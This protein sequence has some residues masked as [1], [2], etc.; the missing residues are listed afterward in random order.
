MPRGHPKRARLPV[1]ARFL[2][3]NAVTVL[4]LL[5]HPALR[6]GSINAAMANA[7][8][9]LSGVTV[10]DLYADYPRFDIDVAREQ[11]RLLEHD[12]VVIQ[13]PIFWYAT[14]ALLKQWL[15]VVLEYGFAYG[16]GASGLRGK[17][18]ALAVTAGGRPR[19]YSPDGANAYR[20]EDFLLPLK[21]TAALCGMIALPPFMLQEATHIESESAQAHIQAYPALLKALRDETLD[22]RKLGTMDSIGHHNLLEVIG[23]D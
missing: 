13:F 2:W 15:D 22:L 23:L 10:V 17:Q 16:A 9:K 6:P 5:V 18:V 8:R 4:V 7:A 12:V 20:L 19:D 1:S 21:R 11:Q 14:P 3:G